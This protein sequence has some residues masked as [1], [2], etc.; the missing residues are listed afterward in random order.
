MQDINGV[1]DVLFD[2]SEFAIL[3]AVAELKKMRNRGDLVGRFPDE[4]EGA[5]ARC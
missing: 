4:G 5:C 1:M 3:F 2:K